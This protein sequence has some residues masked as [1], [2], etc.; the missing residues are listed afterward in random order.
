L[1]TECLLGHSLTPDWLQQLEDGS[2]RHSIAISSYTLSPL[3]D[4]IADEGS[5]GKPSWHEQSF[6]IYTDKQRDVSPA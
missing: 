6:F 5:V 4:I 1:I 2:Q 3:Y